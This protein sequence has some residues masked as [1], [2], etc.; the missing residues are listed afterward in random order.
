MKNNNERPEKEVTNK[1]IQP[2]TN[3]RERKKKQNLINP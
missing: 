3:M 1:F 2:Q